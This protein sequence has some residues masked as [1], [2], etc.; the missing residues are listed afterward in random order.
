M[1]LERLERADLGDVVGLQDAVTAGLPPGFIRGKSRDELRGY[2]DGTLGVAYGIV[3]DG[4][5]WA[6]A[7]L[8]IPDENHPNAGP[9]FP[10]VPEEDWP[11]YACFLQNA[12]VLPAARG[13]GYQRALFD[14][15]IAHA[16]YA[17]MRWVCG[18]VQLANAVSWKNLLAKGM[19]I[20]GIR[21]DLGDPVVG[22]LGSFD[23]LALST[24]SSDQVRVSAHDHARQQAALDDGCIGV[25]VAAD[26]AVIYQRLRGSTCSSS[27]ASRPATTTTSSSSY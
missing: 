24:D 13:R 14:A 3:E 9:P 17:E 1:I 18:G 10:L 23:P 4:A 5:L 26:G 25:R 2:L 11:L 21:F 15:R 7:L 8:R 27:T 19:V 6:M 16:T 20:A 12:M 22:L